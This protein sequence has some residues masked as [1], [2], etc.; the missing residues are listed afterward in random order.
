MVD[1]EISAGH[2]KVD[3]LWPGPAILFHVDLAAAAMKQ[4]TKGQVEL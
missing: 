2:G 3:V 4:G 1:D